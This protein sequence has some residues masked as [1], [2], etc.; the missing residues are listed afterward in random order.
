MLKH[1]R[2]GLIAASF[3]LSI[4]LFAG[5]VFAINEGIIDSQENL[6]SGITL[7][8]LPMEIVS[9]GHTYSITWTPSDSA[10]ILW[11]SL[12]P[13][14]G[15]PSYYTYSETYSTPGEIIFDP[16]FLPVGF[17][18]CIIST[19][20]ESMT[21]MEFYI[22]R[23]STNAV[24][25]IY[26][27]SDVNSSSGIPTTTPT[28]QWEAN[29]GVPY[30]HLILSD[31]EF[32]VETD[33]ETGEL[34][35][36]G[37]NIV[38]E[39][40]TSGTSITYGAPD[41]S[42]NFNN[43]NFPPLVGDL[44]GL[45]RPTYNWVV[46]N[47]FG[48][49]PVLTSDVVG[50]L[51]AFEV[52]V[53]PPFDPPVLLEP[54]SGIAIFDETI[55]FQWTSILEA[56]NYHLYLN[57]EEISPDSA[58]FVYMPIWYVQSTV[59]AVECPAVN[60]LTNGNYRWKIIAE[61]NQGNGS[62]GVP[63][64]FSYVVETAEA[65]F[66]VR[67]TISNQPVGG[68]QIDFIPVEG[69]S[70]PSIAT[71][72]SGF[73]ERLMPFGT[74]ILELSKVGFVTT[75]TD[76]LVIES[77]AAVVQTYYISQTN[78]SAHGTVED[79]SGESIVFAFITA[80][81]IQTGEEETTQS[82]NSG[83]FSLDLIPGTWSFAASKA[84][85]TSSA[86]KTATL[87]PD[88]NLDLDSI[89]GPMTLAINLYT[90]DG[91]V[92]NPDGEG[93]SLADVS[94]TN[95][96]ETYGYTTGDGGYYTI[97]VAAGAWTLSA[98]KP[99]F[100]LSS[101][102][103]PIQ[104]INTG[105]TNNI[106]LTPAANIVSGSVFEGSV[107]S[108]GNAIV[109]AIPAAGT[110]EEIQVNEQGGFILSLSTGDYQLTA[111]LGGYTSPP[112]INLSLSVGETI[113]GINITLTPNPSYI[114]GKVTSDGVQ[115][116]DNALVTVG[117]VNAYT[118]SQGNYT[119]NVPAGPHTVTASKT[120]YISATSPQINVAVAQTLNNINLTITPNAATI[121]GT[122]RSSGQPVYLAAVEARKVTTGAVT[123]LQTQQ[124]GSYSFGL[125]YGSYWIKAQKTG[126][127]AAAPESIQV[128]INP[129]QTVNNID[130]N[131]VQNIGYISGSTLYNGQGVSSVQV[132][133]AALD[134]PS[135]NFNTQSGFYGTFNIS[136][137]PLHSYEIIVSK[138][139][140]VSSVDT[141]GVVQLNS[142]Q[143]FT[144]N[145]VQLQSQLK[146][147]VYALPDSVSIYDA[148][149][150]AVKQTGGTY[151]AQTNT[152]GSYALDLN[153]GTYEVTASK[154]GY[155]A[156]VRDTS[157]SAG[158]T[159]LGFKYYLEPNFAGLQGFVKRSSNQEPIVNALVT[160]TEVNTQT[161]ASAFTDETGFYS[162]D[163]LFQGSYDIT[164]THSQ[165]QTGQVNGLI[166][167]GGSTTNQNINLTALSG[168]IAGSA[169]DFYGQGVVGA[170]VTA[171]R[172]SGGIYTAPTVSDG[173]YTLSNL[174]SGTYT[175]SA[176]K[177]GYTVDDTSGVE[178][179]PA[180][181]ITDVDFQIIRNDGIIVGRVMDTQGLSIGGAQITA[182]DGQG[183]FGNTTTSSSG[184][185]TIEDLY[186]GAVFT[187]EVTKS[188]YTVFYPDTAVQITPDP[189]NPDS[190]NF[191]LLPNNLNISGTVTNQENTPL[192]DIDVSAI[193]GGNVL[194]D[195]TNPQ[196]EFTITEI[197]P[198][199]TYL[200]ITN[201]Y[202]LQLDNTDTTVYVGTTSLTG[203]GLALV[204]HSSSISGLTYDDAGSPMLNIQVKARKVGG[205]IYSTNTSVNGSYNIPNLY[206]GDYK[207]YA[208]KLG[209]T[210]IPDTID[211]TLGVGEQAT[212]QDFTLT[213]ITIDISGT[214]YDDVGGTMADV[215]VVAWSTVATDTIYTGGS[216]AFTFSD[217]TPS[218][219]Y[220]IGTALP[221][222]EYDNDYIDTT[223]SYSNITGID[224]N[225]MVHNALVSGSV[226][227]VGTGNVLNG[228]SVN[229]VCPPLNYDETMLTV[230]G[231]FSFAYLHSGD[232]EIY[233][234]KAG[235]AQYDTS[236]SLDASE[237][238]DLGVIELQ[239]LENAI[240]GT[241]TDDFTGDPLKNVVVIITNTGTSE[242]YLD[243]TGSTG[244]YQIS[245]LSTISPN[246]GYTVSMTK[247]GFP[248]S[249]S[250]VIW[251]TT[252]SAQR[253]FDLMPFANSIYG[254][255]KD[256]SGVVQNGAVVEAN[257]FGEAVFYDTTNH[258]GDYSFTPLA[259]G[260]Y[261][262][263]ADAP[264]LD[265][266]FENA[267]LPANDRFKFDLTVLNTAKLYGTVTYNGQA[268]PG[269]ATVTLLN[270]VTQNIFTQ[271][272][273]SNIET[274]Y[275]TGLRQNLYSAS[276][277]MP[278][279]TV[280]N[281][282]QTFTPTLGETDTVNFVLTAMENALSGFVFDSLNFEAVVSATVKLYKEGELDTSTYNTNANGAFSFQNLSDGDYELWTFKS[283]YAPT[284]MSSAVVSVGNNVPVDQN[285]WLRSIPSSISG[286]AFNIIT[287]LG[288]PGVSVRLEMVEDDYDSTFITGGDGTFLFTEL[289]D[290]DY[291]LSA[292]KTNYTVQPDSF[293]I[294]LSLAQS[295][296]GKDFY[297]TAE[298]DSFDVYGYVSHGPVQLD[299]AE[300][301]LRSLLSGGK[302]TTYTDA[303][304]Y[305]SFEDIPAPDQFQL[306]VSKPGY[307]TL[308]SEAFDLDTGDVQIDFEYP[309]GQLKFFVTTD[310]ETPL[311]NILVNVYNIDQNVDTT[312]VTDTSGIA[313][314]SD[315]LVGNNLSPVPYLITVTH[316]LSEVL[317]L[318]TYADSL[319]K[320]ATL[321]D[322]VILGISYT[323][324]IDTT[325]I[326]L[327]VEVQAEIANDLIDNPDGF[328][329]SLF[330]KGVGRTTFEEVGMSPLVVTE[331]YSGAA[332]LQPN[333][334]TTESRGNNG[335]KLIGLG[336]DNNPSE[337]SS[338]TDSG[339][340]IYTATIPGQENSGSV[341]YYLEAVSGYRTYSNF[342]N[343]DGY[344]VT[345]LGV[346]DV[347]QLLPTA[348]TI[349]LEASQTF[350]M[351]LFDNAG[352]CLNDSLSANSVVWSH[353]NAE[354]TSGTLGV[355][356]PLYLPT[357]IDSAA[358]SA[359]FTSIEPGVEKIKV[360]VSKSNIILGAVSTLEIEYE[361]RLLDSLS[362]ST[363]IEGGDNKVANNDSVTFTIHAFDVDGKTMA[364]NPIWVFEPEGLGTLTPIDNSKA[365]FK[366][367]PGVIGQ[368]F[369]TVTDSITGIYTS[370]NTT[371]PNEYEWGL[372]VVQKVT[373]ITDVVIYDSTGFQLS[374]P[375]GCM[376]PDN[377]NTIILKRPPLPQV[378]RN[379]LNYEIHMDSYD[380][381]LGTGNEFSD[382]LLS[383]NISMTLTLPIPTETGRLNN[384][385]G[386][387][388][389][390]NLQW[391]D[392]GGAVSPDNA[393]ITAPINGFSE[394]VVLGVSK[395]LGIE[396]LEFHPNPFSPKTIKKLQI[397]FI[398]NSKVDASPQVSIKIF[399]MRGDLVRT[400]LDQVQMPKG[401]H[402][403]ENGNVFQQGAIN[404]SVEWD[405]LTDNGL[406]ARNGRY[407]V[408]IKVADPSGDEEEFKTAVLIK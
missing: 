206:E 163:E 34:T 48:N 242:T 287:S 74:Y 52:A 310:G 320:D 296:S 339:F 117:G 64:D 363:D 141:S 308:V 180:Q 291:V 103:D 61:D 313:Q 205:T 292:S 249:T 408:H 166:L 144:F 351:S 15:I 266:Y 44:T 217:M 208:T 357:N 95:G 254:T 63:S 184:Y 87:Q 265:S 19:H 383:G 275:F 232:Y 178:L 56:S 281:S 157:L 360:Q 23:E 84:G 399:N 278:G 247:K 373:N 283:G 139:G 47:C 259:S 133:L 302:D 241:I 335:K 11:Y 155:I 153:A 67:S 142:T 55:T 229:L 75:Q 107:L 333:I 274:F 181:Q 326:N 329:I 6:D 267:S 120:G 187:V 295:I 143:D 185:F 24:S 104:I 210:V 165:Y 1:I 203:V 169:E 7:L 154:P 353:W 96:I 129:G 194:T 350:T 189:V 384:V 8:T 197:A 343:K 188:G 13:G 101:T 79:N 258:F 324:P 317:S 401:A 364:I 43:L 121:N 91:Y 78:A 347:L 407:F 39:V 114:S 392:L 149:V 387:W 319:L 125:S 186:T 303:Q 290:G 9:P 162:F 211:L 396:N 4:I 276:A 49:Y 190:A 94:A 397:E 212:G 260:S 245:G 41:P 33:P 216:G 171:E 175:I 381:G 222:D 297:L 246:N 377:N 332:A 22:V 53:A 336:D 106:E 390:S 196:G 271:Q 289:E 391:D 238:L 88:D 76:E 35:T 86:P 146:G 98:E 225:V 59:N 50:E 348:T 138:T 277:S 209:Y 57:K 252:T 389:E 156:A 214:V 51:M 116:V 176:A 270:T 312:L 304:G 58:S 220:Q 288:L 46:L 286:T 90:L 306:R 378:K 201:S 285:L 83:Y 159:I 359:V 316:F 248:D 227:D 38:W 54:D 26:P 3:S 36:S 68:V 376:A 400:L 115:P 301:I 100:W 45:Y 27:Q 257:K 237:G 25:M 268:P 66:Y 322:T 81:N 126:F 164:Y 293:N 160:A 344:S 97:D 223:A 405:G 113:S 179:A 230:G 112:P 366:P 109:Q 406:M 70:L 177:D 140:Y 30:Y 325:Q 250:N 111:I 77:P 137:T 5:A 261:Q 42:N 240:Y 382:D 393:T 136:V 375:P 152:V 294:S 85:Y 82:N 280:V 380:L 226:E 404:G 334:G 124:D 147:K 403:Y 18:Y 235:Y 16:E 337:P 131:L 102:L 305:Y 20:D 158:Q 221:A 108:S 12:N 174:P 385:I 372:F 284:E 394:F 224:L 105:S 361:L 218:I 323:D 135:I 28:F 346:P 314:T 161:G 318:H 65:N 298:I 192:D 345:A 110:I 354:D 17:L 150:T 244:T 215:P 251:L 236:F 183:N 331:G 388:D 14:A 93:V 328:S 370:Y 234:D 89:G 233:F 207:I 355:L 219:T 37:A 21:S 299:G 145:M 340:T 198:Q 72:N 148:T 132:N 130:L 272:T 69:P 309:R 204:E 282:P 379:T 123:T 262:L 273:T 80:T 151:T 243:T 199:D 358:L 99:A 307:F 62:M 122:V 172:I 239:A 10:G 365:R 386:R 32:E 73:A 173:S 311:S 128:D 71:D 374:I 92:V 368:V 193:I 327:P 182:S 269:A 341:E 342:A 321:T 231:D 330:Y 352:N 195:A 168:S 31:Q 369:F 371:K 395:P 356:T 200:V 170:T 279:F 255:V 60:L 228:V 349:Q 256:E 2:G 167:L 367:F 202:N 402:Y 253:N 40:I 127:A 119:V 362:I 264:P 191:T 134:D 118:G 29:P 263:H 315:L 398:L 338:G 300:V 213:P